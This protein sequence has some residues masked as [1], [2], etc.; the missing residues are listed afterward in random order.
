MNELWDWSWLLFAGLAVGMVFYG[1]LWLTVRRLRQVKRPA[2][3]MSCSFII[4][5]LVAVSG[6]IL[7]AAGDWRRLL[8]VG[9]GFFLAR[10]VLVG[11]IAGDHA[12]QS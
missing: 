8:V 11:T 9:L 7:L 2:L 10:W 12:V 4:R 3:W 6:L 1:G 5:L